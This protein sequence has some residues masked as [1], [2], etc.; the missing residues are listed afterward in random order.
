[1]NVTK[2]KYDDINNTL[3]E[4]KDFHYY[5]FFGYHQYNKDLT[6]YE[7]SYREIE[8]DKGLIKLNLPLDINFLLD[9]FEEF[10]LIYII[11]SKKNNLFENYDFSSLRLMNYDKILNT[12]GSYL[13]TEIN[14]EYMIIYS[15]D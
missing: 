10:Q 2:I 11:I 3:N 5:L 7:N 13:I 6:K 15:S 12:I 8:N 4:L 14:D 1:M 9:V